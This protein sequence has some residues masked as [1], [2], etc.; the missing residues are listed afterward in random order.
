[1][2]DDNNNSSDNSSLQ[3]IDASLRDVEDG[4]RTSSDRR[5]G[6]GFFDSVN[7]ILDSLRERLDRHDTT[8]SNAANLNER[9]QTAAF[10]HSHRIPLDVLRSRH[11]VQLR[12]SETSLS[13]RRATALT[14]K[15]E[16][17]SEPKEEEKEADASE[18]NS[19]SQQGGLRIFR[20]TNS[21]VASRTHADRLADADMD[22]HEDSSLALLSYV[23]ETQIVTSHNGESMVFE[24]SVGIMTMEKPS[25]EPPVEPPALILPKRS[26]ATMPSLSRSISGSIDVPIERDDETF[27][28]VVYS[29]GPASSHSLHDDG[30]ARTASEAQVSP[31]SRVGRAKGILSVACGPRHS[32]YATTQGEIYTC[33]DNRSGAV[34]PTHESITEVTRPTMLENLCSTVVKQVSCGWDHTAALTS[35][36]AVLAWGGNEAGQL[37]HFSRASENIKTTFCRPKTMFL[38]PGN[39]A[40]SVACG[41]KFTLVLTTRMSVLACGVPTIA[42]YSPAGE[43]QDLNPKLPGELPALVGLPLASIAAGK[44]HAVVLTVHGSAYAWGKNATGCCGRPYPEE[45]SS[46]VPILMPTT[47]LQTPLGETP[48][49]NW[50]TWR[51]D[52]AVSLADD[53]AVVHAACGYDHTVLVTRSGTLL[54]CGSNDEGQLGVESGSCQKRIQTV[55]HPEKTRRF[56]S[57]EAGEKTTLLLDDKGDVF[58]M[59]RETNGELRRVLSGKNIITIAV[60]GQQ[61]VAVAEDGAK[62]LTFSMNEE[63][64]VCK[65]TGSPLARSLETLV[66]SVSNEMQTD[67]S[68]LS[69]NATELVST[70][71]EL[72]KNPAV[73]NSLFLDPTEL[74]A[75]FKE[76]STVDNPQLQ[77]ALALATE[78]SIHSALDGLQSSGARM[79]YPESVRCLLHYIRFFERSED[80]TVQF[81][82]SGQCIMALCE[83]F[84]SLP[85]EGF[86]AML[87]WMTLYPRDAFV[88]M[89]VRPLLSQLSRYVLSGS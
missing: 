66:E 46:P 82:I 59:G 79:I 20:R 42:G 15:E 81:D 8:S 14:Q 47:Q 22:L 37:G 50:S 74:D 85:Y 3:D 72:L 64:A 68:P 28:H 69:E 52:S 45:S 9:L 29:W 88:T 83:A 23:E 78:K 62:N 39:R 44:D 2:T 77:Q 43:G 55:H 30:I 57:A 31:K 75:L 12:T 5:R 70:T 60:G 73:L 49:H 35:T 21:L 7:S 63:K 27:D 58:Q 34:D 53:V 25:V 80:S 65:S 51:K 84:L 87:A 1:M 6:R 38:G 19:S 24:T 13:F 89:L 32:A 16:E 54:V 18:Y 26:L 40:A 48:F 61:Y 11:F 71:S 17:E 33:G 41:D 86:K 10:A 4:L 67:G 36:G 56:I 76:I